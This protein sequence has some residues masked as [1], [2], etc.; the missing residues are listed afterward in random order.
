MAKADFWICPTI[1]VNGSVQYE[2]WLIPVLAANRQS[3]VTA[4]VE[5]TFRPK[6]LIGFHQKR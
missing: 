1:D 4:A 2:H 6:D 5:L 3:D